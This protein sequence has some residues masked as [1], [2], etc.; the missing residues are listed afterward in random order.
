MKIANVYKLGEALTNAAFC[1]QVEIDAMVLVIWS[2][3]G[4]SR[5]SR[6]EKVRPAGQKSWFAWQSAS[7]AD[8]GKELN[9][10][11]MD[12]LRTLQ[13]GPVSPINHIQ[14]PAA[15]IDRERDREQRDRETEGDR[16]RQS[17]R[18]RE[19]QRGT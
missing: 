19:T 1:V 11:V 6:D 15:F 16:D 8:A 12:S 10:R 18:H 14:D 9:N 2:A 3:C 17:E 5:T 7:K 13:D 4:D